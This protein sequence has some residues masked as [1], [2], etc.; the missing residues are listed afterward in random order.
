TFPLDSQFMD[1]QPLG[2]GAG[3]GEIVAI[4]LAQRVEMQMAARGHGDLARLEGEEFAPA[5]GD[6]GVIYRIAEY[7]AG[8]GGFSGRQRPLATDGADRRRHAVQRSSPAART[9]AGKL[10]LSPPTKVSVTSAVLP[11]TMVS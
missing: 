10:I 7:G 3:G 11:A 6:A 8:E 9:S 4:G 1:E 5:D 2:R